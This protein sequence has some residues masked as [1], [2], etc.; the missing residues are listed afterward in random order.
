VAIS[1]L[2]YIEP[3]RLKQYGGNYMVSSS[4]GEKV[5]DSYV[6]WNEVICNQYDKIFNFIKRRVSNNADAEDLTQM[7]CIEA[8]I[9]SNK[10]TGASKPETWIFGIAINLIK[11]YYKTN[12][13][14]CNMYS[15]SEGV[16]AFEESIESDYKEVP[17][18]SVEESNLLQEVVKHIAQ[19]PD[20][21]KD[22]FVMLINEHSSYKEIAVSMEIP[23]GTVRSRLSRARDL[24][25]QKVFPDD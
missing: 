18:Y 12:K 19:L 17:S 25:K 22:I 1:L 16:F 21:T 10:F 6:D 14:N 5:Y 13:K 9:N 8:L 7:T 11:N 23:I 4:F 3:G 20:E 24:L 15:L 2:H